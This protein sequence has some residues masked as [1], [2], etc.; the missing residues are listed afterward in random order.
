MRVRLFRS[1]RRIGCRLTTSILVLLCGLLP[2][3]RATTVWIDA[4]PSIGLPFREVDDAFALVL[5]FHSP[6]TRIVGVSTTY[7]NASLKNTTRIGQELVSR[8][9]R[10][11]CGV[12]EGARS[13]GDLGRQ[14]EASGALATALQK[15]RLTYIALGPLTNL[16][17][18]LR[19]HP[20][21]AQQID[22]IILVGGQTSGDALR[23]GP[24]RWLTIHDANILKD[25]AAVAEVVKS[26]C[27]ITLAP[28]ETGIQLQITAVDLQKARHTVAGKYLYRH[29]G[30]WS[31]F[32]R[33]VVGFEGGPIFDALPILA[34]VRPDLVSSEE[35]YC[36]LDNNGQLIAEKTRNAGGRPVR[37]YRAL[38]PRARHWIRDHL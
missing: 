27:P 20:E 21:L 29:S 22:R 31:W 4:D 10:N 12:Y 2:N 11:R 24:N 9:A 26:K 28:I 7:G 34:V 8:F 14:T 16:A 23:L 13:H 38:K 3:A 18:L 15:E 36:A 5:A 33:R 19:L 35:R 6:E 25:S 17:T 32:W 37:I 1:K 30:L